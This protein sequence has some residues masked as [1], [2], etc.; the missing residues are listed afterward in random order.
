MTLDEFAEILAKLDASEYGRKVEGKSTDDEYYKSQREEAGLMDWT[1]HYGTVVGD[2]NKIKNGLDV[3]DQKAWTIRKHLAKIV[4][5]GIRF[6]KDHL[7]KLGFADNDHMRELGGL[8]ATYYKRN[9]FMHNF[10]MNSIF[11]DY[12]RDW[13]KNN[14]DSDQVLTDT[15]TYDMSDKTYAQRKASF[16]NDAIKY[17]RSEFIKFW[18]DHFGGRKDEDYRATYDWEPSDDDLKY[19]IEHDWFAYFENDP[20]RFERVVVMLC[21]ALENN[22]ELKERFKKCVQ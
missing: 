17:R 19:W 7:D 11:Y 14:F 6:D 4:I 10:A 8:V 3:R 2:D 15:L 9:Q 13:T 12:F 1:S 18:A 16:N 22:K 5:D 21:E 20:K